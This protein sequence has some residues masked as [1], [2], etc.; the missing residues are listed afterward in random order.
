[1]RN[2]LVSLMVLLCLNACTQIELASHVVKQVFPPPQT[3]GSFKVGN[4]YKIGGKQYYPKEEYNFVQT[5]IASWYGPQFHG[6]KTAN[7]ETFNMH[8]LTAAHK[9]LQM[10]SIVRVTNLENGRSLVV[11]INDRGPYKRGRIIDLSK[12]SAELLGFKGQGTAKVKIEILPEESRRIAMLAKRGRNTNGYE[13]AMNQPRTKIQSRKPVSYSDGPPENIEPAAGKGPY[14]IVP[15]TQELLAYPKPF[16]SNVPVQSSH[17]YVQAGAF[18]V[19]EN[20]V[21]LRD[22]LERFSK[23]E[24]FPT[25]TGGKKL[26]RVRLAATD[27]AQADTLLMQLAENGNNDAII[28]VD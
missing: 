26:Y 9:T 18:S 22:R 20:A 28:I 3:Q 27:V 4:P 6:K 5:G 21:K 13:V 16:I 8:E 15:V 14:R 10:P 19:Y 2:I 17:I 24:I 7:G 23:V 11:R 25:N 1:M 12:K